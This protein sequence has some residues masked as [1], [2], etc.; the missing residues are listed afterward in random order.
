MR[1]FKKMLLNNEKGGL[2]PYYIVL[3]DRLSRE[4][5][6][7]LLSDLFHPALAGVFFDRLLTKEHSYV[8]RSS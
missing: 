6:D 7:D 2:K 1:V 5:R 8:K 3:F 4:T